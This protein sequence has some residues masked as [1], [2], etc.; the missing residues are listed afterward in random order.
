MKCKNNIYKICD[1]GLSK[2]INHTLTKQTKSKGTLMY[3]SPEYINNF[4]KENI[5]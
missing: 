3:M 4:T 1:F 2:K 5:E